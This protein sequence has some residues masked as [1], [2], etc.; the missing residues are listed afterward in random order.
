M[1]DR[2]KMLTPEIINSLSEETKK[3]CKL[4][5]LEN[6]FKEITH[7]LVALKQEQSDLE[8]KIAN[9]ILS[10]FKIGDEV[11]CDVGFGH[12]PKPK[13]CVIEVENNFV[14]ARPILKSGECDRRHYLVTSLD[15]DKDYSKYFKKVE[16]NV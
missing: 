11:I 10:P 3:M 7:Q 9:T 8:A 1:F 2:Y 16:E 15:R 4:D 13:I 14:Y 12:T 6:R 5:C